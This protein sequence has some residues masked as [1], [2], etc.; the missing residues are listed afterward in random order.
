MIWSNKKT[1]DLIRQEDK[2]HHE[3]HRYEFQP[4]DDVPADSLE[5]EVGGSFEQD[6]L[7]ESLSS[8]SL[9]HELIDKLLQKT[10]ELSS[11]LAKMQ[12]QMEK[13]QSDMEH[14]LNIAKDNSFKEGL[15]QG[16]KKIRDEL[17]KEVNRE[18]QALIQAVS[19]LDSSLR[20]SRSRLDQLEKELS[21]VAIDIAREVVVKELNES[22]SKVAKAL[23]SS[24]IEGV[25]ETVGVR[26]CINPLDYSYVR[27]NVDLENVILEADENVQKGGVVI[28]SASGS[29]DGNVMTRFR[30]LKQKILNS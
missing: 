26:L 21:E 29:I 4:M 14:S 18:K 2:S 28:I 3:I 17:E 19:A 8:Q 22:S 1:H 25:K 16:E 24:L 30:L 20:D 6:S 15:L 23:A 12:I 13:Q 9:E 10:D 7:D 5:E 11:S 27:Q